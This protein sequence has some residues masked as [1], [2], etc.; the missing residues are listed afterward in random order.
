MCSV[1]VQRLNPALVALQ[2]ENTRP[3]TCS[4]NK[5][6]RS[7]TFCAGVISQSSRRGLSRRSCSQMQRSDRNRIVA[8]LVVSFL[9]PCDAPGIFSVFLFPPPPNLFTMRR[10]SRSLPAGVSPARRR[11][12]NSTGGTRSLRGD[13]P[14]IP[15]TFH[16]TDF[17]IK[18]ASRLH[19]VTG[20][21][22]W[23]GWRGRLCI[24]SRISSPFCR[25]VVLRWHGFGS[26][27]AWRRREKG[28]GQ[29]R[30][31]ARPLSAGIFGYSETV[32]KQCANACCLGGGVLEKHVPTGI[33]SSFIY[34]FVYLFTT[35]V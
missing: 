21:G 25:H 32:G 18:E 17:W 1:Q 10:A 14:Q 15:P 11:S 28:G 5:E 19:C 16:G 29:R 9:F 4:F 22:E 12:S 6:R 24:F 8:H 2:R 13:S 3:S 33:F 7:F 30:L 35:S 20:G 27:D 23:G 31:S 34:L 26:M